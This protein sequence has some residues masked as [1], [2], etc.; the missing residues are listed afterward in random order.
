MPATTTPR[1][2]P[3]VPGHVQK[4]RPHVQVARPAA[5][6]HQRGAAVHQDAGRRDPDHGQFATGSGWTS[7]RIASTPM[8]PT[9]ISSTTAFASAAKMEL[10]PQP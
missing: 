2:D 6:E 10:R 4:R 7:R 9:L 3:G 5:H 8:A 1:R